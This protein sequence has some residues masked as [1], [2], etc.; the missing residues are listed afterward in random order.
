MKK[1]LIAGSA[2]GLLV[3]AGCSSNSA[4][5]ATQ[6]TDVSAPASSDEATD[7]AA[8][9]EATDD[10]AGTGS[11]DTS[12]NASPPEDGSDPDS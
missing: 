1:L 5:E 8:A 11:A 2:L 12:L 7:A 3:L 9:P 6:A 10:S 4:D